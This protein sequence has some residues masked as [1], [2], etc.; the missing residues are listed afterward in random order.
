MGVAVAARPEEGRG[1]KAGGHEPA[2]GP[3]WLEMLECDG[4]V[5]KKKKFVRMY[6][7][8][9][10]PG[11]HCDGANGRRASGGIGSR[12]IPFGSNCCPLP[13]ALQGERTCPLTTAPPPHFFSPQRA[14]TL[15]ACT[16][17]CYAS[18]FFGPNRARVVASAA[19]RVLGV[20]RGGT[21]KDGPFR[22]RC[23]SD[24]ALLKDK[25]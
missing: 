17:L 25:W 18:V 11:L 7:K 15:R 21:S 5:A 9:P 8:A 6:C 23:I 16:G 13:F 20:A 10:R 12:R 19:T 14:V 4:N 2:A 24:H 1:S 3:R 22:A